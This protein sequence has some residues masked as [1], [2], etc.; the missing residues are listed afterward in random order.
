MGPSLRWDSTRRVD[1]ICWMER[2]YLSIKSCL[3]ASVFLI[4]L[5]I[6]NQMHLFI[7]IQTNTCPK[8]VSISPWKK[9]DLRYFAFWGTIFMSSTIVFTTKYEYFCYFFILIAMLYPNLQ[10]RIF[11]LNK[12]SFMFIHRIYCN[13]IYI[14]FYWISIF[15]ELLIRC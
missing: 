14:V 5:S 12:V 4:E 15:F 11:T 13:E 1:G 3:S 6:L 7:I 9:K 2:R 10:C 8:T